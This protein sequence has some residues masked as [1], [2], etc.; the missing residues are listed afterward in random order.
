[1]TCPEVLFP[2]PYYTHRQE[3]W[4]WHLQ[5]RPCKKIDNIKVIEYPNGTKHYQQADYD[6]NMRYRNMPEL[7]ELGSTVDLSRLVLVLGNGLQRG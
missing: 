5:G 1:M 4:W 7:L 3:L 2:S 6:L